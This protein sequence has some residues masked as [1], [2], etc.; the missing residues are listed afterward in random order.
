MSSK[1]TFLLMIL[2]G[3]VFSGIAVFMAFGPNDM[4]SIMF[5]I[6]FGMIGG[7]VLCIGIFKLIQTIIN[8]GRERRALDNGYAGYGAVSVVKTA[9]SVS[10]PGRKTS[11]YFI[12]IM[13]FDEMGQKKEYTLADQFNEHQTAYLINKE[14]IS[15]MI[16][17]NVCALADEIP[18]EAYEVDEDVVIKTIK[19]AFK[20]HATED[21]ER[22][23]L[24]A[25]G[26]TLQTI[27]NTLEQTKGV[28]N[29]LFIIF[30]I[31]PTLI[32]IMFILGIA[33]SAK[34]NITRIA[35]SAF[36]ILMVVAMVT[37]TLRIK[38]G[39]RRK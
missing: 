5:V 18:E 33:I 32:S 13:F 25:T 23:L 16:D 31:V 20:A 14:N 3:A 4:E 6:I 37:S 34:D 8:S 24:E 12:T 29:V 10:S 28:R 1:I 30:A 39:R 26:R 19:K 17:G 7:S 38:N 9:M 15:I 36:A 21:M 11:Y 35:F 22:K 27:D 2:L